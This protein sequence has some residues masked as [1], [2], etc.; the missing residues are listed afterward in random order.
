MALV[1]DAM[2]PDPRALPSATSAREAGQLFLRPEVR[3]VFVAEADRLVGVITR[4]TLIREVVAAG[5]DPGAVTVG[6]IA[7]EAENAAVSDVGNIASRQSKAS[8][9]TQLSLRPPRSP[10]LASAAS[11]ISGFTA[12]V[13]EVAWTRL[14]ALVIGPTTYAFATMVASFIV[15]LAFGSA[16]GTR[17]GRRGGTRHR[18][19]GAAWPRPRRG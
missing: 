18:S 10:V 5:R 6:E 3:A 9:R 14:L 19:P 1:R 7:E 2:V 12:L 15:G 13:Y 16:A 17:V 11:A 8:L 4:G